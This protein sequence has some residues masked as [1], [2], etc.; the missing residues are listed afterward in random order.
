MVAV[1]VWGTSNFSPGYF[2]Q[3]HLLFNLACSQVKRPEPVYKG[4]IMHVCGETNCSTNCNDIF[5]SGQNNFIH[6]NK[7]QLA[8]D[9]TIQF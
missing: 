5:R 8:T 7:I 4:V 2:S 3:I 1:N 6:I 9:K